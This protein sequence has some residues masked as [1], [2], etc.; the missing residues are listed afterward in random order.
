LPDA[1]KNENPLNI[2]RLVNN[3][4]TVKPI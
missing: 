3:Q 1:L 4:F 2:S